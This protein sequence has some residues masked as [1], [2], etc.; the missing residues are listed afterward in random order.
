MQKG[1]GTQSM[2]LKG[3]MCI[4]K[5][6]RDCVRE[7]ACVCAIESVCVIDIERKVICPMCPQITMIVCVCMN[8][9]EIGKERERDCAWVREKKIVNCCNLACQNIVYACIL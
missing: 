4:W 6:E 3:K 9:R 2:R 5:K 7:I 8:C 1:P